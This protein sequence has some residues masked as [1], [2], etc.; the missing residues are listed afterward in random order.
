M[1]LTKNQGLEGFS[2]VQGHATAGVLNPPA[3]G[4]QV[5]SD[6]THLDEAEVEMEGDVVARVGVGAA[7]EIDG[8][9]GRVEPVINK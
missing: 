3:H 1:R 6:D 9:S 5:V 8:E 2:S 4:R 7:L